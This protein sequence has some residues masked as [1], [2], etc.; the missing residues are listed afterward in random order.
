M[1][2]KLPRLLCALTGVFLSVHALATTIPNNDHPTTFVGP[3]LKGSYSAAAINDYTAYS[4][5]GELGVKNYR[6]GGTLGWLLADNQRLKV[7]AEY[8][9]QNI[10]YAF[11]S[12]N[13]YQWVN[14]GAI[15]ADYQYDFMNMALNPQ[16]DLEAYYSHAPSKNLNTVMGSYIDA[17]GTTQLFTDP[18]RIAGSNADGIAP[19]ITIAPWSGSKV[20]VDVNYDSV[21]YDTTY[22]PSHNAHGWGGTFHISQALMDNITIGGTAGVRKPFNNYT[23]YVDWATDSSYGGTW[24]LGLDGAYTVGKET[25]PNTYNIG[26]SVNYLMDKKQVAVSQQPYKGM[27]RYKDAYQTV[28]ND[29][30]DWVQKPAVYM[31]QVLAIVDPRQVTTPVCAAGTAPVLVTAF[32]P[33]SVLSVSSVDAA[34]NFSGSGLTFSVSA[35]SSIAPDTVTI[36]PSTGVITATNVGA[37]P[38]RTGIVTVTATN[39]CG[40]ASGTFDIAFPAI[41]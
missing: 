37:F 19:G 18:R 7:S 4:V 20:G 34:P 23:A 6:V 16:F 26:L 1:M 3:T 30:V 17:T 8:L 32:S 28:N 15:G 38:T 22:P 27:P 35:T 36:N 40:S 14:Q 29:F 41:G 31:P 12:G 2:R 5:L 25:L 33:L 24:V 13:S 11:F 39:S 10:N 21:R 9:W